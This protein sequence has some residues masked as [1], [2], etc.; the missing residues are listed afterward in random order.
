METSAEALR[1]HFS[2]LLSSLEIEQPGVQLLLSDRWHPRCVSYAVRWSLKLM[3]GTDAGDNADT[4]I[5]V[6]LG[7]GADGRYGMSPMQWFKKR[8]CHLLSNDSYFRD[9]DQ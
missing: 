1:G 3:T 2:E 5:K 7:A 4:S 6:T 9:F 8:N